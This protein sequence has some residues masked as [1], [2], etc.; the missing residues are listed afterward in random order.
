MVPPSSHRVSRV[1][2]Y[3]GS[4]RRLS[5]FVYETFTLFGVPSHALPLDFCLSF[6]VRT[7]EILLPPVWPPPLSLATTRGISVDVFSCPYLDVSVQGVPYLTL[8]D[9]DKV[10][11]VLP[12][13]VSPFGNLRIN[14][15]V[16]L[17][18][19]YRSLSRPSSAPDAKAFPLRSY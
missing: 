7:P 18:E 4:S 14:A 12:Y 8:F 2:R 16:P 15:Y 11:T 5:S 17:P 9:S 13:R 6:A 3:S 10:D 1:R 19:A